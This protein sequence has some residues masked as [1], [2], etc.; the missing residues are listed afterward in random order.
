MHYISLIK[1]KCLGLAHPLKGLFHYL[2]VLSSKRSGVRVRTAFVGPGAIVPS[3][4]APL[5]VLRPLLPPLPPLGNWLE[6]NP[7]NLRSEWT[8]S[9][10]VGEELSLPEGACAD[11]SAHFSAPQ[12][13]QERCFTQKFLINSCR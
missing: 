1:T 10:S 9:T 7:G 2:S 12:S 8:T 3:V 11:C 6:W 5:P 4:W 13:P